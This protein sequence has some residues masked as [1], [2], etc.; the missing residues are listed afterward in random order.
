[1]VINEGTGGYNTLAGQS[2]D[3][4]VNGGLAW[5]PSK[6]TCAFSPTCGSHQRKDRGGITND[7]LVW[8]LDA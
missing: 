6:L 1:M 7:H 8:T 3:D 2:E 5:G 4:D